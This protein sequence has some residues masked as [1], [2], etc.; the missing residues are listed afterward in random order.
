MNNEWKSLHWWIDLRENNHR[1]IGVRHRVSPN[2]LRK[3]SAKS[4]KLSARAGHSRCK[5]CFNIKGY[6]LPKQINDDLENQVLKLW[7]AVFFCYQN[8]FF[9]ENLKCVVFAK[10][11]LI[12]YF[13]DLPH[14]CTFKQWIPYQ[15]WCLNMQSVKTLARI[16]EK[17]RYTG[18][19]FNGNIAWLG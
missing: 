10:V 18:E 2:F 17:Y 9:Y 12:N 13:T 8:V 16:I 4:W 11:S 5:R 19:N 1:G 3:N 7:P 6:Y 14:S 15:L